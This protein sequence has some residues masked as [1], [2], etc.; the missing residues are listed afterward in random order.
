ML[1]DPIH[2]IHDHLT[3]NIGNPEDFKTV[4]NRNEDAMKGQD[5]GEINE[6]VSKELG[7][8]QKIPM[9][10]NEAVEPV[11]A[12]AQPIQEKPKV[13]EEK[14]QDVFKPEAPKA[15]KNNIDTSN[16]DNFTPIKALSTFTRDWMILARV[17]QRS[18]L[19]NTRAG[20]KLL[21]IELVDKYG[22]HIEATFFNDSAE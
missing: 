6:S 8:L 15:K 12:A 11:K 9:S 4:M 16:P 10:A 3:T 21:K 20:G 17:A 14:M 5:L 22:T 1:K 18:E 19:R 2:I 13:P 7:V